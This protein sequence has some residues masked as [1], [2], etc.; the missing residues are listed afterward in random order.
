MYNKLS[1]GEIV[2]LL[3]SPATR[4]IFEIRAKDESF[5]F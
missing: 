2:T 1:K 3:I 5:I 4:L